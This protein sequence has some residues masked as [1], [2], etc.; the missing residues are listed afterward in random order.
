MV[1]Q[2]MLANPFFGIGV[3]HTLLRDQMAFRAFISVGLT[4]EI[5][6]LKITPVAAGILASNVFWEFWYSFGVIGTL[7][8]GWFVS[9]LFQ[10]LKVPLPA[11]MV[12]I[13]AACTFWQGFGGVNTPE[14]WVVLFDVAAMVTLLP[15]DY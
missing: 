13:I 8:V 1:T 7:A 11:W 9:H 10:V 5:S 12:I 6:A 3:G 2:T 14:T 4:S 15:S